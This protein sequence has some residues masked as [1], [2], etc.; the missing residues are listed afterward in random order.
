MSKARKSSN[1]EFMGRDD[2]NEPALSGRLP[3]AR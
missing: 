1:D 3:E 2:L